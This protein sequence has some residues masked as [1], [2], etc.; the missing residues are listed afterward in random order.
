LR[1]QSVKDIIGQ[2]HLLGNDDIITKMIQ[3]KFCTSLIF[4]GPPGTGKT[5]FATALAKDLNIEYDTFNAAYDKKELLSKIIA[6]AIQEPNFI[7][8]IDEIHRMNKDKQDILLEYMEKGNIKL[9]GTTTENPFF[10]NK[11]YNTITR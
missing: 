8:I 1:P 9:F 7:L 6:K 5:T 10:C 11:S 2:T 4:Y 3:K